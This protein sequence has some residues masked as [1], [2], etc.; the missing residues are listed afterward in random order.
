MHPDTN[1][2]AEYPRV[3]EGFLF[4]QLSLAFGWALALHSRTFTARARGSLKIY[5]ACSE[6]DFG[7]KDP[8]NAVSRAEAR[9]GLA[10]Q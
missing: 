1:S 4:S 5:C 9:K 10:V 3:R 6:T 7:G 8:E 2:R